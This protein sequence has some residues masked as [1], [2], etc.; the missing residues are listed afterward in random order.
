ML[1]VALA[2]A[3]VAAAFQNAAATAA[4]TAFVECLRSAAAEAKKSNIA[5]DG[6]IPHLRTTCEAQ[7]SKLKAVLIAFDVKN[8]IGRKQAAG[9]ADLQLED[10]YATQEEKYRYEVE[11]SAQTA[12]A[13]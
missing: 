10:F 13:N 8:G 7:G 3:I 5:V 6:F 12:S 4:R 2:S 9:D 1:T 11:K